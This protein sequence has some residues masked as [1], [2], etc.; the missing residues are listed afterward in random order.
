MAQTR[1][2]EIAA[3]SADDVEISPA[4]NFKVA[5]RGGKGADPQNEDIIDYELDREAALT[6]LTVE[7]ERKLIRR[8]DWRLVPLLCLLYLMKKIDENNVR[9]PCLSIARHDHF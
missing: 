4:H 5:D 9:T 2:P 8:V 1:T 7:E 3:S 6:A